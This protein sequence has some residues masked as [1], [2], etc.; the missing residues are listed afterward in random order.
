[1]RWCLALTVLLLAGCGSEAP[2]PVP[3]D[4]PAL[5]EAL[6]GPILVDPELVAENRAN[7]AVALPSQD[8]SLPSVDAGA[9]AIAAARDEALEM[10]GGPGRMREAPE[11]DN[12]AL[13]AVERNCEEHA[14][15]TAQ[16]AARMPATFPVYPRGAVME[17]SGTDSDG[18][19]LRKVSFVTPVPP[20]EVIDFYF[21]RARAA[22]YSA[23]HVVRK[24]DNLLAGKKGAASYMISVV[25]LSSG[26]TRV[27]L[28]TN[29]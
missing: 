14:S 19:A 13:P 18:C 9:E 11:G 12:G 8:G 1:M 22:G 3:D 28:I 17:A 29:R 4:D 16:W 7:S 24:E 2:V 10:V 27:D 15:P 5:A 25:R 21:T 23:E 20:G 26:N 6:A